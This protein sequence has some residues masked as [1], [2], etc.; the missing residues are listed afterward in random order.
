MHLKLQF[1]KKIVPEPFVPLI[2]GS[3]PK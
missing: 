1:E 3:S 2:G